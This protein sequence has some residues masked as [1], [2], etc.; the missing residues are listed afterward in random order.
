MSLFIH[1]LSTRIGGFAV[2]RTEPALVE[3]MALGASA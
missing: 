3:Y 2:T 1:H